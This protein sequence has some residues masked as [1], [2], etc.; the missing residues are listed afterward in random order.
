MISI[1]SKIL[2]VALLSGDPVDVGVLGE[3]LGATGGGVPQ[4][5]VAELS[6]VGDDVELADEGCKE[7]KGIFNEVVTGEALDDYVEE[8]ASRV[9]TEQEEQRIDD[10][11]LETGSL[12]LD[13]CS[14]AKKTTSSKRSGGKA[15][16]SESSNKKKK[17]MD[18]T[19]I[20]WRGSGL[21]LTD[22]RP[23]GIQTGL[24]NSQLGT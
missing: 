10:S 15:S 12:F 5:L 6:L 19:G 1:C 8:I 20:S 3:K 13:T 16:S 18:P 22:L 9:R 21:Q 2:S 17:S 23:C 4:E 14:V 11:V 24:S 7:V